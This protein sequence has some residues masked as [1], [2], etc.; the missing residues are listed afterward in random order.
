MRQKIAHHALMRRVQLVGVV[1]VAGGALDGVVVG[2]FG[3]ATAIAVVVKRR[4][5]R[6]GESITRQEQPGQRFPK[7]GH[8]PFLERLK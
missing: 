6:I 3:G 1:I 8:F 7:V 4:G 2:A 5:Q